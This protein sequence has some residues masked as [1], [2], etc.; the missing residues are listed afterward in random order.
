VQ[1]PDQ[2]DPAGA[3]GVVNAYRTLTEALEANATDALTVTFIEGVQ[4]EVTVTYK[5]LRLRALRL[6]HVLQ[7]RGLRPGDE[8]IFFLRS[9]ENF[10]DAFWACLFGGIVPVPVAV[11][12]S[13]E[14]RSKVFRIFARLKQARLLTDGKS[15]PLLD[16]FAQAGGKQEEVATM[17]GQTLLIEDAVGGDA[18]GEK[19]AANAD[20]P[21]FIQYSSG[22]TRDPKGVRLTHRNLLTNVIDIATRAQYRVGDISLS[23]MPLTHDMGL[24]GFHINMVVFGISQ[25]LMATD[26]FSRRPLLWL[27]KAEEKRATVLCSPNF[28]Y[29]HYLKLYSTRTDH[30]L[31]LSRVRTI[32]NGAEPISVALCHE[33]LDTLSAHGLPRSSIYPAYGLAEATV[34]VSLPV[35]GRELDYVAVDRNS[36]TMGQHVRYVDADDTN[37]VRLAIEGPPVEHCRVRI[38]GAKGRDLGQEVIGEL[39]LQGANVTAGYYNDPDATRGLFTTDGWLHTGDLGFLRDGQVVVTGRLKDIIFVNGQNFYPHDLEAVALSDDRLEIGKVVVLG[40][41]RNDADHDEVLVCVL[42]RGEL[43]EFVPIVKSVR[44]IVTKHTGVE[45]THVLPVRRIP[46]TTSGKVQRRFFADAYLAGE[47][48]RTIA[49]LGKLL[50]PAHEASSGE[51]SH[52]LLVFLKSIFDRIVAERHVGMQDDFFEIGMSSLELAQIHE[53]VEEAYPGILDITD[54]FDHPTIESLADLLSK[55]LNQPLASKQAG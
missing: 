52:D 3:N 10:V 6:L 4:N 40:V 9:N 5:E 34:A 33:F 31:D 1:E 44:L 26:L 32:I 45:V 25:N 55:K 28:G 21:A 37:A 43:T 47:F 38:A 22:S 39:Q 51:T 53:Q 23:W 7:R 29:R 18:L 19:Y 30:R 48:D 54:L 12:I 17:R 50:A 15:L 8:L 2:D 36:L 20:S 24:I 16:A 49:D 13:D 41:R 14:H 42:F 35:P 46:K 11:G 27:Q